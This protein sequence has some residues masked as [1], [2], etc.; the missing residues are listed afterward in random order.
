MV[1]FYPL[2]KSLHVAFAVLSVLGFCLR[3]YWMLT[4]NRL[5]RAR[6]VLILPH[7]NDSML[8]LT[9]VLLVLATRMYPVVTGW[10]TLKI[11]LLLVYIVLG[12]F[13]L[14]RGK[15][16]RARTGFLVAAIITVAGI[17]VVALTKPAFAL[18]G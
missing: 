4:D 1:E 8:L 6:A 7:I 18:L 12:T 11:I 2:L 13:A 5:L 10:V 17:F 16:R 3:G 15:S 14:K 9:A